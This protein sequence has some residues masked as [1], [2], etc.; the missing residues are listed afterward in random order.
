MNTN[1]LFDLSPSLR[2]LRVTES[3]T[4]CPKKTA[5]GESKHSV[6]PLREPRRADVHTTGATPSELRFI[7]IAHSQ[8]RTQRPLT[9]M[10]G[11]TGDHAYYWSNSLSQPNPRCL[12]GARLSHWE[13]TGP[14]TEL[15]WSISAAPAN[16]RFAN[17]WASAA[18]DNVTPVAPCHGWRNQMGKT[19]ALKFAHWA[20]PTN[21]RL[22]G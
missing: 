16:A 8:I 5:A 19:R 11:S 13:P 14:L 21:N 17:T 10:H 20:W 2:P 9:P 4:A 15:L 12:H 3:N 7:L 6:V 18:N 22:K 1:E